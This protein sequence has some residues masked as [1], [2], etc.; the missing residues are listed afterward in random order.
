MQIVNVSVKVNNT[1][2][3]VEVFNMSVNCPSIHFL[4]PPGKSCSMLIRE[5]DPYYRGAKLGVDTLLALM[6]ASRDVRPLAYMARQMGLEL[7]KL[8]EA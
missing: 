8:P 6:V 4:V 5:V 2:C 3:H 7:R 1:A